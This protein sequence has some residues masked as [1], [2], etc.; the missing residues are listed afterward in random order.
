LG[1]AN[2]FIYTKKDLITEEYYKK[3]ADQEVWA[4]LDANE[5]YDRISVAVSASL[6]INLEC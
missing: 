4:W 1:D 3:V 6:G 2:Q 5:E